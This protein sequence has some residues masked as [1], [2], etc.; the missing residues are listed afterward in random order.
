MALAYAAL[1]L[2]FGHWSLNDIK[3]AAQARVTFPDRG[4]FRGLT[5]AVVSALVLLEVA[6][7]QC[8]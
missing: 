6:H 3:K 2:T 7:S 8:I 1:Q 4:R 5:Q